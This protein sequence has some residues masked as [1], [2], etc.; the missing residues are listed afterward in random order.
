MLDTTRLWPRM[1]RGRRV[2][3]DD[4]ELGSRIAY[5]RERRGVTQRLLADRIGRSKSWIEKVEAGKR[6]ANRLPLLLTICEELRIDLPVLIGRD[7]PRDTRECINDI[8]VEAIRSALERYDAGINVPADYKADI[9]RLQRQA[10]YAWSAFEMSDYQAVSRTL[11]DLLL[12]AQRSYTIEKSEDSARTL[13]EAYQ[14]TASTLRKLGEHDLAWLAG[15]RG[16]ALAE[17]VGDIIP[18]ALTGFRVANAL[19]AVGRPKAAYGLNMSLAARLEPTLTTEAD[20]SAYGNLLLQ[21]AMAAASKGD[22]SAVRDLIN[23]AT[24]VAA[25]V[26][27]RSNHYGLSFGP[28]NV[29]IHHVSALV[30]LG[31]GGL[32]V[33]AAAKLD[34]SAIGVLR[35]ERRAN[36]LVDVA[37]GYSQ[38][39]MRDKALEMLL[40]AE[41]LAPREVNCRPLARNTIED[42]IRRSR[43]TP[44][45]ALQSLAERSGVTG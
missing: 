36:H 29:G 13:V 17:S 34:L 19:I 14:I 11:P 26:S 37:R 23:E 7:L 28:A 27:D 41:T 30:S 9:S 16:M 31:E 5:W 6:S 25:R 10:S 24:S 18:T 22:A 42:L 38:W 40:Q 2:A 39:G 4:H 35:R 1:M 44:T 12:Q 8:Q 21:A 15:D 33:E 43:G 20:L 3:M 32:A 45:S